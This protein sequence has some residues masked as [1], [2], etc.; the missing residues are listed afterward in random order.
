MKQTYM[1]CQESWCSD[2]FSGRLFGTEA[3]RRVNAI[4]VD[5]RI[6]L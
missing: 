1:L 3:Y 4:H 2:K 6:S 5:D